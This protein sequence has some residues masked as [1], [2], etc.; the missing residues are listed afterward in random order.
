MVG[1]K[2]G[3]SAV[4]SRMTSTKDCFKVIECMVEVSTGTVTIRLAC[5]TSVNSM[6]TL[7]RAWE[8]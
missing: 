5:F 2:A 6:R 8:K 4:I 1:E 7:F 3:A